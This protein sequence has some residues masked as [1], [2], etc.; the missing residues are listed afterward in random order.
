ML[1]DLVVGFVAGTIIVAAVSVVRRFVPSRR[2]AA[3]G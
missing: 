3:A 1:F 2:D